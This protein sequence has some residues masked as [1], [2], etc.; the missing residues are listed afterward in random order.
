MRAQRASLGEISFWKVNFLL[1]L[2]IGMRQRVC[3]SPAHRA[4]VGFLAPPGQ[5]SWRSFLMWRFLN[6]AP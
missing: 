2:R 1:I 6:G 3:G 4:L 5:I